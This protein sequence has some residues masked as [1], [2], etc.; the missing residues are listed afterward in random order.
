MKFKGT[1]IITDPCYI[2]RAKHHGTTPITEDD[3]RACDYGQNIEVLG[4]KHYICESTIYGDWSCTTYATSNPK[5][6]VDDLAEIAKYFN[7][8][9]ELLSSYQYSILHHHQSL[10]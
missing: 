8:K 1:I 3:W 2:M 7:D 9:Y 4:I 10:L 5:K 6:A